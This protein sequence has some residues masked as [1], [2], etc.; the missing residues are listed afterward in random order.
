MDIYIFFFLY[1][2][3]FLLIFQVSIKS[4]DEIDLLR[5]QQ[6]I[7]SEEVALHSSALKRLSQEAARNPQKYQIHVGYYL[8]IDV[9]MCD[10]YDYFDYF[11]SISESLHF[12]WL[13]HTKVEMERLK[14]EIK[15][16]KEQ[17][18]LLERKIADSFIVKNKLDESGVS[19]VCSLDVIVPLF[20]LVLLP[21][22]ADC[23]VLQSLTELMT[24][25]NE[26]SFELEVT[27]I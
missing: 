18:D 27:I 20:H 6:K 19:L 10:Q 3:F 5:E 11:G 16:K 12:L 15:S 9:C 22:N 23:F 8:K 1:A 21:F 25:L 7:L 17:I 13:T 4:I 24:Q 26:K 14:D 2:N